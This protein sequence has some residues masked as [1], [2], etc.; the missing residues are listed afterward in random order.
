MVANQQVDTVPLPPFEPG[1]AESRVQLLLSGKFDLTDRRGP[2]MVKDMD[3][4]KEAPRCGPDRGTC[5]ARGRHLGAP[6]NMSVTDL[7]KRARMIIAAA[8]TTRTDNRQ[9]REMASSHMN[10]LAGLHEGKI[11]AGLERCRSAGLA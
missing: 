7:I 9:A 11:E 3:R 10:L 6:V 1:K 5:R 8:V 4:H 2:W